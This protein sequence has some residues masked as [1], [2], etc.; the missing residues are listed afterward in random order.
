M[1]SHFFTAGIL[2]VLFTVKANPVWLI[3][4]AIIID[5]F[6]GAFYTA[7]YLSVIMVLWY[8]M[9]EF[10]KPRIFIKKDEY[11]KVA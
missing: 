5:A 10:V 8:I 2:V 7:P 6:F 11:G 3:P 1:Q 4:M 9:S